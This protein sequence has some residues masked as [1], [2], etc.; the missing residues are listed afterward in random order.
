MSG[1]CDESGFGAGHD[2]RRDALSSQP[3]RHVPDW[4]TPI[5]VTAGADFCS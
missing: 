4:V 3:E 5:E 2:L 1:A